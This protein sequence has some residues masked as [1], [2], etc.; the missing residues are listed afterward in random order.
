M[1]RQQPMK[2]NRMTEAARKAELLFETSTVAEIREARFA[3]GNFAAHTL[4]I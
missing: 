3:E 4:C 2:A 1:V